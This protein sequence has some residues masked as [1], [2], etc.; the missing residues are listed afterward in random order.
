MIEYIDKEVIEK[1]KETTPVVFGP[2]GEDV[3]RRTYSRVKRDGTQES[4]YETVARVVNGNLNYVPEHFIEKE[5]AEKLFNLMVGMEIIP[6]GRHLWATGI[7]KDRLNNCFSSDFT[8][9]FSEHFA[10]TLMRLMEGGGVGSNYSTLFINSKEGS[11]PWIPKAKVDLHLI[12][13]PEHKDLSKTLEVDL[14]DSWVPYKHPVL[15]DLLSTK[16]DEE[17]DPGVNNG[18]GPIYLRVED[19]REGWAQA[20]VVLLDAHLDSIDRDVVI[21]FSN[22][23][24]YGAI[25]KGF[26][27]KASGPNALALLLCRTNDLLNSKYN[28]ALSGL[29]IMKLDHFIAQAVVAGGAR[30]SARMSMKYWKDSDIFDFINCKSLD[31]GICQWTTNISVVIDRKFINA[32]KRADE[33]ATAVFEAVTN[34]M[35]SNGEPG[36]INATKALEGECPGTEFYTSN[37]CGEIFMMRYPDMLCFDVCCLGHVNLDRVKDPAEAFRLMTRFLIRATFA[38][39]TDSRQ[40]ANVQRNRRIGVGFL[41]YHSWL[42]KNKIKYS[43]APTND[44]IKGF[45]RKMYSIIDA[46]AKRYCS[47]LRIPECIKKTTLAPT[48]SIGNLAGCTTGCQSVFSKFYIRR[49]RYSDSDPL[50]P[51]LKAKGYKIE[52]DLYAANT[53]VVEYYCVDPIYDEV[54]EILKK[55]FMAKGEPELKAQG[56]AEILAVDLI[57]DQSELALEDVLSTQRM[58]QKEFVDNAISITVNVNSSTVN[59][60]ELRTTLKHYL[61]DLKGVTIFPEVS[62]SQTPLERLTWEELMEKQTEGNTIERTQ[63]EMICQGACPIK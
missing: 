7:G 31:K 27:G 52:K 40:Y 9:K 42:V 63:A 15:G 26:G 37:P 14:S 55:D 34:G 39:I 22:V 38:K 18:D 2:I 10:F 1:A 57:E 25:L 13:H 20:L 16:Y 35:L 21:D 51:E 24:H 30:R 48:G 5:E 62:M 50:L 28:E 58:L 4:W 60:D 23:R 36:F 44:T 11:K 8:E 32:L 54:V 46:E 53:S 33:H 59:K 3:Y 41:G 19:S 43:D 12:C 49:V 29:D 47:Q 61:P 45:F 6:G 56:L 17:W